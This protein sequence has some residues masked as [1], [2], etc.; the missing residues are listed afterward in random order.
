MEVS[1]MLNK[2]FQPFM[3]LMTIIV[4]GV[5]VTACATA[6]AGPEVK[7][8][9][10]IAAEPSAEITPPSERAGSIPELIGK[11]YPAPSETSEGNFKLQVEVEKNDAGGLTADVIQS[12]LLDDSVAEIKDR[13]WIEQDADGHYFVKRAQQWRKCYRS[14]SSDWMTKPCP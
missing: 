3:P 9:D 7:S 1:M 6:Q 8:V 13:L 10:A 2:S 4:L 11:L 5:C 12:G 14:A